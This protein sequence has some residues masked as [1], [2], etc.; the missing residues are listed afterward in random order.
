M[1]RVCKWKRLRVTPR[2]YKLQRRLWD[3]PAS[4]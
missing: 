4:C 2:P 1:T 3:K